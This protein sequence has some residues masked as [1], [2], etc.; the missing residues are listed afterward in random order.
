MYILVMTQH[1]ASLKWRNNIIIHVFT[2]FVSWTEV[3]GCSHLQHISD[4]CVDFS[5]VG[6]ALRVLYTECHK[7]WTDDDI[8]SIVDELTSK[9]KY[10]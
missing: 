9:Y 8:I 1:L 3:C 4:G 5:D 6:R 10:M 2:G 7:E